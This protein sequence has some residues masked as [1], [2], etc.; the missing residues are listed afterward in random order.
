MSNIQEPGYKN[1]SMGVRD[2]FGSH[3]LPGISQNFNHLR[4]MPMKTALSRRNE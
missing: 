3:E 4:M 2:V 1:K